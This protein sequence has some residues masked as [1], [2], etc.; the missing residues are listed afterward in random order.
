MASWRPAPT[1]RTRAPATGNPAGSRTT[2]R[3]L[4]VRVKTIRRV[5]V[6]LNRDGS[7]LPV[8]S[9]AVAL[10]TLDLVSPRQQTNPGH[11]VGVG[12]SA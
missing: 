4:G 7:A 6:F 5:V 11:A 8:V 3:T 9:V 1:I 10:D 12:G 2:P